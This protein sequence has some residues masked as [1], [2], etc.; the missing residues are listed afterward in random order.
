[1]LL[2][3][4]LQKMGCLPWGQ[5]RWHRISTS[6][7]EYLP[8]RLTKCPPPATVLIRPKR[9]C[10]SSLCRFAW[11]H[12]S[13]KEKLIIAWLGAARCPR[14]GRKMAVS[15]PQLDTLLRPG[16]R[17]AAAESYDNCKTVCKK[18]PLTHVLRN[19][20]A[21]LKS[22]SRSSLSKKFIQVLLIANDIF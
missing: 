15:W 22:S 2:Q 4:K 11:S 3:P 6:G 20:A 1:M 10:D 14:L 19:F 8:Q 18:R 5:W 21:G 17:A 12:L 13:P 7:L 16:R 9:S